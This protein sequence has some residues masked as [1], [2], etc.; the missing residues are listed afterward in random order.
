MDVEGSL[1]GTVGIASYWGE[2]QLSELV[3]LAGADLLG[4]ILEVIS[5]NR[6]HYDRKIEAE[7]GYIKKSRAI[8]EPCLCFITET[9]ESLR[10]ATLQAI[11]YP[12]LSG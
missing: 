11:S 9:L 4:E 6:Q 8:A 7:K 3:V 12:E 2:I 1:L 10:A 5:L